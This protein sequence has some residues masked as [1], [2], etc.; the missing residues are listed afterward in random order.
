[1]NKSNVALMLSVV[2][3][4]VAAAGFIYSGGPRYEVTWIPFI[5]TPIF[6]ALTA[7]LYVRD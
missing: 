3:W 1:M 4:L 5:I 2:C 7:A 6:W